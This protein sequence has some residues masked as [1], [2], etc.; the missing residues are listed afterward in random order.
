MNRLAFLLVAITTVAFVQGSA[1]LATSSS[2][3][4]VERPRTV[5]LSHAAP[6]VD[7]LI[8]RLLHAL[9]SRDAEALRR[10]RVTESE[11]ISFFLPGAAKPDEKPRVY[12]DEVNEF[13]WGMLNTKSHYLGA[14]LLKRFGGYTMSVKQIEYQKDPFLTLW[15][16]VWPQPELL[17]ESD[18][19]R[20]RLIELGSIVEIDGQF[21]F[22]S[23]VHD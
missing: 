16:R 2:L 1:V 12:R 23:F 17:V 7:A 18:D 11:Y 22:L 10:L 15:Y 4:T 9:E 21:K 5:R 13:A 14:T 20:E 19:G 6:T 8:E 3:A